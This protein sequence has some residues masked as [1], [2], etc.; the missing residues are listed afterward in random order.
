MGEL[1][2]GRKGERVPFLRHPAGETAGASLH[3]HMALVTNREV[4]PK[5]FYN[6][7]IVSCPNVKRLGVNC[8]C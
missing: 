1:V 5:S 3:L 6:R 2:T 4:D 7:P 8:A